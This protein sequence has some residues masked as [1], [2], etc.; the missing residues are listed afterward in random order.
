MSQV[1]VKQLFEE[2]KEKL[3]LQWGE[4]PPAIDRRLENHLI[5]SSTQ[6]LIG[7]LNF[8]H[9]NWIQVL[10]QI[11]VKYLEQLD[12]FSLQKRLN[13]L[14]RSQ[15]SCLIVADGAPIP[16]SIRQFVNEHSIPLI[17]SEIASLEIIWGL[18]TYL[19]RVLAPVISRHGVLLDVL[20]MGVMITGESGVG[21]SELALE[22]ISRGHGLVADDVVEL[23]RIGPETL[24]GR[25]P[26]LLRDFLEVRGLGL[27]NIR[28]IFGE[29]AIRRHKNMKL[30]VQLEKTAGSSINAYERLPLS[31]L[32]E[33]ILNVS[34]RK[35]TIP[36]AAG[37]N[38]AVL[39]EAAVRNYILQLR[40]IDSTQ[41]FVRRH[42]SEMNGNTAEHFDDPHTE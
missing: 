17:R 30:I 5:A 11:S 22:L 34:I 2:N 28:T 12:D 1:S 32:N 37:R 3:C 31:N 35:V 39:V 27:L 20:G 6:E 24:E 4:P 38:L 8:V 19:V 26:P 9:P 36:V 42:E 33:I 21:K 14:A 18:Q 40:G 7:H 41:E 10:N 29:T 25:C 16:Y 23:R 15:L 13:Q